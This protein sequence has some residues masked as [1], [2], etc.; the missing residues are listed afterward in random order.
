MKI[1]YFLLG[2]IALVG[3]TL[4]TGPNAF[5][6]SNDSTDFLFRSQDL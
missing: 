6:S 2:F 3:F 1:K 4:L 5:A